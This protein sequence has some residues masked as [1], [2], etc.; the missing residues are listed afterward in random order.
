MLPVG[1]RAG[2]QAHGTGPAPPIQ[3]VLI[4]N[5]EVGLGP[6]ALASSAAGSHTYR[7]SAEL[8]GLPLIL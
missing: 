1:R 3:H 6:A 5:A 2:K 7:L 8:A 4:S